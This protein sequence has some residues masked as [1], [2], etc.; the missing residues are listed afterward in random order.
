MR[1]NLIEPTS[2]QLEEVSKRLNAG[3]GLEN[4]CSDL[5]LIP[6]EV[7]GEL[8]I[9]GIEL[10]KFKYREPDFD[11]PRRYTPFFPSR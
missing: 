5:E 6:Q 1:T 9:R 11:S 7:L 8:M 2:E 3:E 4:I 10:E